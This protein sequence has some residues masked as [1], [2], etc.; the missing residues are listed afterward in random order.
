MKR[1]KKT[2]LS[3]LCVSMLAM[4]MPTVAFAANGELRFS[5]PTASA[6]A[7]VEV[8]AKFSADAGITD[9]KATL[10]YDTSYLEFVS[11]DGAS[12]S[13][14]QIE[15]TGTGDGSSTELNWT[16]QFRAL[17]EGTG[18]VEVLTAT[19]TA[20]NGTSIQ[21]TKGSSTVTIVPGDG[22]QTAAADTTA[23]GSGAAVDVNGT[24]YTVNN[25]FSDALIP[26]GFE[27]TQIEFEGQTCNAAIQA[28]SGKYVIYLT[29]QSGESTF[30]LY[31]PDDGS[32][33]PFEQI[34]ISAS[35][36]II[37]L[38]DDVSSNLPTGYQKTSIEVEGNEFPA[39]QKEGDV[40]YYVVYALNSDGKKG[41]YQYDVVD[42]TYQRT[43]PEA[44]EEETAESSSRVGK[45][46]DKVEKYLDIIAIV[47]GVLFLLLIIILIVKSVQLRHR[48]DELDELYDKYGI[49]E[50]DEEDEEELPVKNKKEPK[51]KEK[52][53]KAVYDEEDYPEM[54]YEEA[55][56]KK[57]SKKK[58]SQKKSKGEDDFEE[59]SDFMDED[60]D[61]YEEDDFDDFDE[62]LEKLPKR[63]SHAEEDDT[64]KM[65][66]IDLD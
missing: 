4:L 37:L 47:I 10:S 1:I 52:K 38:D 36:Y 13:D 19:G 22:T 20:S 65:D 28:S 40:D 45:V 3:M 6:G 59:L 66:I 61:D 11:G 12:G 48:D 44:Q 62:E 34:N 39:W 2:I 35:R 53:K 24:Q 56:R 14:G 57:D 49:D 15:L 21:V 43:A 29:G 60:Y 50:E 31:D 30:F 63:R 7:T 51:V 55:V 54:D 64:F 26:Q 41:F 42:E 25:D 27:R 33:S 18:K 58:A 46:L 9:A 16:L 23:V 32:I 5:D 17:A 8:T